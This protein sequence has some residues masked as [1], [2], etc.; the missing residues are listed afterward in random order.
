MQIEAFILP[1][2]SLNKVTEFILASSAHVVTSNHP[3]VSKSVLKYTPELPK[4]Q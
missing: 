4:T 1:E 3:G 2:S